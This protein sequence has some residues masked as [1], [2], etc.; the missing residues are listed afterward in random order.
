MAD[1]TYGA[2]HAGAHVDPDASVVP[3]PQVIEFATVGSVQGLGL[4][5]KVDGVS[6]PAPHTSAVDDEIVYPSAHVGAH[7]DPD[8]TLPPAPHIAEFATVGNAQAFGE[9][10]G[11]IPVHV[12]PTWHVYPAGLPVTV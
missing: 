8:T 2:L 11:G 1:T 3:S 9:H 10:D 5:V 7:D 4:H 12:P 6:V